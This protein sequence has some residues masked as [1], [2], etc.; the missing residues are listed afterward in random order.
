MALHSR[1]LELDVGLLVI[2]LTSHLRQA[3]EEQ[4]GLDLAGRAAPN[5]ALMLLF[6]PGGERNPWALII[7]YHR[8]TLSGP[9]RVL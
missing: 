4:S 3:I 9:A 6:Q 5:S 8:L 7:T 2:L 1:E